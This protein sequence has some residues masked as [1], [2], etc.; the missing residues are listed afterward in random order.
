M[1]FLPPIGNRNLVSRPHSS[2]TTVGSP[3]KNIIYNDVA[4]LKDALKGALKE[5]QPGA[6][7]GMILGQTSLAVFNALEAKGQ[8]SLRDMQNFLRLPNNILKKES[9]GANCE[10]IAK[11]FYLGLLQ[12][13]PNELNCIVP[14]FNK[15]FYG[16]SSHPAT[17]DKGNA[18][19]TV[20]L[21]ERVFFRHFGL[22]L[23]AFSEAQPDDIIWKRL[24]EFLR[25]VI[26]PLSAEKPKTS[27]AIPALDPHTFAESMAL[28][29]G[30]EWSKAHDARFDDRRAKIWGRLMAIFIKSCQD[31]PVHQLYKGNTAGEL[32]GIIHFMFQPLAAA[33]PALVPQLLTDCGLAVPTGI[34]GHEKQLTRQQTALWAPLFLD[35]LNKQLAAGIKPE[36]LLARLYTKSGPKIFV[37]PSQAT[38]AISG[39]NDGLAVSHE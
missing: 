29:L 14:L 21:A 20:E 1:S 25:I 3:A 27:A 26:L 10:A 36:E 19:M 24:E 8:P 32:S 12:A 39:F 22:L 6:T 28:Q 11:G 31:G 35:S 17:A 38:R 2:H 7:I 37:S 30:Q 16:I 5:S 34:T 9:Q 18:L 15:G 33:H 13:G 4:S 23:A